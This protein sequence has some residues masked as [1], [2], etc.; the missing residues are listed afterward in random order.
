MTEIFPCAHTTLGARRVLEG[1]LKNGPFT[2]HPALPM[3][4][5]LFLSC[6]VV[7]L[8]CH[9]IDCSPPGSSVHGITPARLLEWVAISFSRGSSRP[10]GGT[11]VSCIGKQILYD[12]TTREALS[13]GGERH[14]WTN[15]K[16]LEVISQWKLIWGIGESQVGRCHWRRLRK[17]ATRCR[18]GKDGKH[19][20]GSRG[21]LRR[22]V[23]CDVHEA[24]SGVWRIYIPTLFICRDN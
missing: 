14:Q 18:P 12:W 4:I 2:E 13:Y 20:G 6:S 11:C 22:I 9:P 19:W 5:I 24:W 16:V 1:F 3:G 21:C 10:R 7:Q 8:F 17:S 23:Q 15:Q